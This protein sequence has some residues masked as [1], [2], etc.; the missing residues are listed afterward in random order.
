MLL[1]VHPPGVA[2]RSLRTLTPSRWCRSTAPRLTAAS[3]WD[4]VRDV[5]ERDVR[6]LLAQEIAAQHVAASVVDCGSGAGQMTDR[7]DARMDWFSTIIG[8]DKDLNAVARARCVVPNIAFIHSDFNKLGAQY[9][10][11]TLAFV[12]HDLTT[13][14][15]RKAIKNLSERS[16]TLYI[17]DVDPDAVTYEYALR[18]F[19]EKRITQ[20]GQ[21]FNG[22]LNEFGAERIEGLN[23]PAEIAAWRI[24]AGL[25]VD[26]FTGY[27][28][29]ASAKMRPVA[30]VAQGNLAIALRKK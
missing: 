11:S 9:H 25:E 18:F 23:F 7:L 22:V 3:A 28:A 6:D 19:N 21:H 24:S 1:L 2:A 13:Y 5:A 17:L 30:Q 29:D 20:Y 8:V 26:T 16:E 4:H 12:C 14:A 10:V 15:A 27:T